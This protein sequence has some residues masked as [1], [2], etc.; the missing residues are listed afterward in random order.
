MRSSCRV[1]PESGELVPRSYGLHRVREGS[2]RGK[3]LERT[4]GEPASTEGSSS[5][6]RAS[7]ELHHAAGP[8][9]RHRLPPLHQRVRRVICADGKRFLFPESELVRAARV[10]SSPG[11]SS[12]GALP[13]A[14]QSWLDG[15]IADLPE[16]DLSDVRAGPGDPDFVDALR[17]LGYVE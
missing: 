8:D 3:P 4:P 11:T 12:L 1:A 16:H 7:G 15:Y 6:G 10:G 5:R 17:A 14:V 9:G 2:G 13:D